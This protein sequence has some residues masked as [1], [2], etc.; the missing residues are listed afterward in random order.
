MLSFRLKA[1]PD[2]IET[3]EVRTKLIALAAKFSG[4]PLGTTQATLSITVNTR[5]HLAARLRG[6]TIE[7]I[8]AI[9][10]GTIRI[11]IARTTPSETVRTPRAAI[12]ATAG[13]CHAVGGAL[14]GIIQIAR[15]AREGAVELTPSHTTGALP[16]T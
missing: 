9:A 15:P 3:R 7:A 14:V 10:T 11:V 2:G 6:R 8:I 1:V 5:L 12:F 4:A 16:R 13:A